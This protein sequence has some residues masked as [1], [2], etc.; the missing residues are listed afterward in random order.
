VTLGVIE[1]HH[2]A[3]FPISHTLKVEII[4]KL[5]TSILNGPKY[6]DVDILDCAMW[7]DFDFSEK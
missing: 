2:V 6:L 1:I 7:Q 3:H 5:L 4:I